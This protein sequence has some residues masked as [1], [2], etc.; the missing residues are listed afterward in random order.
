MDLTTYLLTAMLAWVPAKAH[1]ARETADATQA[2]YASIASDVAIVASDPA[3]PPLFQG[4]DGR[5][6]TALLLLSVA[7]WESAFRPDVDGGRC[8]PPEC[9]NGHAFTLWQ[10]HPEDGYI[11]DG[12]VYTY[13]RN[14]S[15]SWRAEHTSEIFDGQALVRDRK[16]AAKI[17]LHILRFSIKNSGSLAIYTGEGHNG[18]KARQ[19]MDYAARWLKSHPFVN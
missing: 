17:A 4:S 1:Q 14:R 13:A 12:D 15:P 18:P 3:E 10:L 9:D 11:F 6:R 2:R 16:L 5:V 7:Y 8:K 19:R